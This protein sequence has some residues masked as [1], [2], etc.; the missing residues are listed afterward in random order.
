MPQ[1]EWYPLEAIGWPGCKD[2]KLQKHVT[3]KVA[4]A[5][6]TPLKPASKK[7]ANVRSLSPKRFIMVEA[8]YQKVW[9]CWKHVTV[10]RF[11]FSD[12]FMEPSFYNSPGTGRS[13]PCT[14]AGW[15]CPAWRVHS[16]PRLRPA[17]W[18]ASHA[19]PSPP[20]WATR[21][22]SGSPQWTLV[23]W[24]PSVH[25][26][27]VQFGYALWKSDK[28][29]HNC[30]M[31]LTSSYP[32]LQFETQIRRFI[33]KAG[34]IS[35]HGTKFSEKIK[36]EANLQTPQSIWPLLFHMYQLAFQ[37][38]TMRSDWRRIKAEYYDKSHI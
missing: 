18:P 9:K 24:T 14:P 32:T 30:P 10:A 5:S 34:E 36:C 11:I 4:N 7:I 31:I 23:C 28:H 33:V 26:G 20:G 6:S 27:K 19:S 38:I 15:W 35:T 1:P 25:K 29:D 8:R 3:R 17:A 13:R 16:R 21:W 22:S 37:K 12:G 2:C